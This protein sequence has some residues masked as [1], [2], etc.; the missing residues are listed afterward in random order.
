M[1]MPQDAI[2]DRIEASFASKGEPVD[3]MILGHASMEIVRAL[4]AA[5]YVIVP[6]EPTDAMLNAARE[7]SHKKYGKPVGNDGASGCYRSM[8][9]SVS[10]VGQ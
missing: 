7:W 3:P 1:L 9:E 4:E 2:A 8:I 5:G 10:Q 6:K